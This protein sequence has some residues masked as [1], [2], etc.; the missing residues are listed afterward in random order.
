MGI[1]NKL[2]NHVSWAIASATENYEHQYIWLLKELIQKAESSEATPDRTGDGRHR[3]FGQ[4]TIVHDMR[5]GFPVLTTKKVNWKAA[6]DETQWFLSGSTDIT[7]LNSSIWDDW[8]FD[9]SIGPMYGKLWRGD[10]D[11]GIPDQL[12]KLIEKIITHPGSSRLVVDCWDTRYLPNED[13]SP[14]VNV[15]HGKMALT[16]C[17]RYWQVYVDSGFID[18]QLFQGSA[19]GFVGVP[20]N[21]VGYAYTLLFLAD[22]TG[23]KPRYFYHTFGDL[24]LYPQHIEKAKIQVKRKIRN[25]PTATLAASGRE[26]PAV[27]TSV[28]LPSVAQDIKLSN[29]NPHPAIHSGKVSV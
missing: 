11:L 14:Q 8:A 2:L 27:P 29:Y 19:D 16:P 18:L 12:G 15:A 9:D 24:H 6:V 28:G 23:L 4:Q 25:P 7:D 21:G 1:F 3:R 20:F 5:K 26:I 13:M 17:H 10:K 22:K